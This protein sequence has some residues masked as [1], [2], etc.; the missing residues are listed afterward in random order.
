MFLVAIAAILFTIS[1]NLYISDSPLFPEA[2]IF[3]YCWTSV[4]L[5]AACVLLLMLLI[6]IM[7]EDRETKVNISKELQED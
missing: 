7:N 3:V 1:L 2:K 6:G 4:F 5:V